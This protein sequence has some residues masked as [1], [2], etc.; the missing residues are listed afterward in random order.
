MKT[1][2]LVDKVKRQDKTDLEIGLIN[3]ELQRIM[4]SVINLK[5]D[6]DE[7]VTKQG[8]KFEGALQQLRNNTNDLRELQRF[9]QGKQNEDIKMQQ[10][11]ESFKDR[12]IDKFRFA[13]ED[14]T[15]NFMVLDTKLK[16]MTAAFGQEVLKNKETDSKVDRLVKDQEVTTTTLKEMKEDI[17]HARRAATF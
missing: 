11:I 3:E 1:D 17:L 7:M 4:H 6:V 2:D 8:Q 15:R 5:S 16:S 9:L 14:F 10:I 13:T 12:I